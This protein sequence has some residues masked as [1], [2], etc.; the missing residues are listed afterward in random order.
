[1][2]VCFTEGWVRG[3]A[4]VGEC[5][6]CGQPI[7]GAAKTRRGVIHEAHVWS[8][9]NSRFCPT[10]EITALHGKAKVGAIGCKCGNRKCP[11]TRVMEA[12]PLDPDGYIGLRDLALYLD[13]WLR[14][15]LRATV[16]A[17][18]HDLVKVMP[19]LIHKKKYALLFDEWKARAESAERIR[20]ALK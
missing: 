7:D 10:S 19:R 18:A 15:E 16:A 20:A 3:Y 6:L 2:K 9:V 14:A 13:A 11:S 1:M 17:S 5:S 8:F 4:L 12:M